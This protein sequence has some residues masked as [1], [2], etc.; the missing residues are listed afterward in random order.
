MAGSSG[1]VVGCFGFGRRD[2][3]DGLQQPAVVEPVDPFERGELDGFEAIATARA[4]G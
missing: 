2:V 1:G 4:D 3:A